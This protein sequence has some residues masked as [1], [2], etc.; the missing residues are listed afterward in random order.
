MSQFTLT[1]RQMFL[2]VNR[3]NGATVLVPA[4]GHVATL[5]GSMLPAPMELSG[6]DIRIARDGV[7]QVDGQTLRPGARLLPYLDYVFHSHVIPEP[8]YRLAAVPPDLNARVILSGGYLTELEASDPKAQGIQWQ[9]MTAGGD[10]TLTQEL[11]DQ[12]QFTLP[13]DEGAKY[14]VVIRTGGDNVQT[15]RLPIPET[16]ADLLLLNA[17]TS[18]K[19]WHEDNGFYRLREYAV[20]YNMTSAAADVRTYPYPTASTV[21]L[22]GGNDPLCGGGQSDGGDDPPPPPPGA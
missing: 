8:S 17:D 16:G 12:V 6:A 7:D 1:F 21:S 14:E 18:P 9:F 11:T 13:L 4:S 3:L 10:V 20:L 15:V 2:L 22:G 19:T 5:S